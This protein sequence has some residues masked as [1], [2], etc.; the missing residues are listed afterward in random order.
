L[1][2]E[3]SDITNDLGLAPKPLEFSGHFDD[4]EDEETTSEFSDSVA[5]S[6]YPDPDNDWSDVV[7]DPE[8][9]E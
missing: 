1:E 6:V 2:R 9:S 4:L 3:I 5:V 7:W 8:D